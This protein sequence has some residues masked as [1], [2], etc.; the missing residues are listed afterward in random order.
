MPPLKDFP[1]NW[2]TVPGVKNYSGGA[3]GWRKKFDN[4]FSWLDTIH[5][6][7]GQTPGDSQD[8]AYA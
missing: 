5:H 6:R 1:W 4:I 3:T 7:D 2:V 8:R